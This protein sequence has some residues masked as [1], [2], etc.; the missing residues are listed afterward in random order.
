MR[1]RDPWFLLLLTVWIPMLW[2]YIHRERRARPAVRFSDLSIFD[3]AP[4]SFA[5]KARHVLPALRM[6]GVGLLI[7]ALARPQR[8]STEQEVTTHGVDIMLA[9]DISTSMKGLDFKPNNRLHVAKE[10][11]KSFITKRD[12][13]RIGLVVF[14]GRSYTKCPLTLDYS[15]LT[16]FLDET[17]FEEIEDGTAIGTAVA[18]AANRIKSSNAKS[19]VIILLTD[20]ANNRGEI[21]PLVAAKAAGELGIRIHTIAVGKGGK[22]PYP[23]EYMDPWTGK[24]KTRVEMVELET[25]EKTLKEIATATNGRFFQAHNREKLEAIYDEIDQLEKT[26]IKTKSYTTY[27]ERFFIWLL[28]GFVVLM[29]ELVLAHT[30]FRRIP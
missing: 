25:D 14:A 3:A 27:S 30:R 22:V 24:R 21:T 2:V 11:I 9:L 6:A 23:F 1:L 19:K 4:A 8:G 26:E 20:G 7:V 13:D 10:T 5:A 18:T 17:R 12:Y 28:A 29:T 16:R 15:I